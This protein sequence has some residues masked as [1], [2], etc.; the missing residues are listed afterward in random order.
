MVC[1]DHNVPVATVCNRKRSQE[2]DG[3]YIPMGNS[4]KVTHGCSWCLVR[5]LIGFTH[6]TCTDMKPDVALQLK[7]VEPLQ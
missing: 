2:V 5:L 3:E 4:L 7:P 1:H 6:I